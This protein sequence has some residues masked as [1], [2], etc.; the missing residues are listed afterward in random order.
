MPLSQA[1]TAVT[2]C[3]T[4]SA[5]AVVIEVPIPVRRGVSPMAM[6]SEAMA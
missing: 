6:R 3:R 2:A 4:V 1:R 5:T